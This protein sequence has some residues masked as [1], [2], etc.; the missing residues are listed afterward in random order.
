[1]NGKQRAASSMLLLKHS[2]NCYIEL[3]QLISCI[4]VFIYVSSSCEKKR[5]W[6]HFF[7]DFIHNWFLHYYKLEVK[8]FYKNM[9]A[10][11]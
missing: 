7:I 4:Y 5:K 8:D 2:V 1:M 10:K 3:V 9:D 11:T 6:N